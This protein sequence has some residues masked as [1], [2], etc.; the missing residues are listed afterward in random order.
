MELIRILLI[1]D[2][3]IDQLAFKRHIEKEKLTF[4]LEIVKSL[5][6]AKAALTSRAFDI[7]ISDYNLGDGTALEVCKIARGTPLVITTGAGNEEIAVRAMKSGAYDYMIKDAERN[8]LKVLPLTIQKAAHSHRADKQMK[9]LLHAIMHINDSVYITDVSGQILFANQAFSEMY[10][11]AA[12]EIIGKPASL[13]GADGKEGECRHTRKDGSEFFVSLS[14]SRVEESGG[15]TAIVVVARDITE[16]MKSEEALRASEEKYRE[17]F[18]ED[19]AGAYVANPDGK[20]VAC[21]PSFARIFGFVSVEEALKF[22]LIALYP[23]SKRFAD[24]RDLVR[25]NKKLEHYESEMRGRDGTAVQVIQNVM[26]KFSERGELLELKGYIFDNTRHKL[27]EE[28]LRQAQKMESIGTLAGGIAHDFNNILAIIMGHAHILMKGN[29]ELIGKANSVETINRAVQ[30]GAKLVKQIL[31]FARRDEIVFEPTNINH[32]L[33]ELHKMLT[34]TFPK[35]IDF[36][37]KLDQGLPLTIADPNQIHQVLLNLCVNARDA[38]P[39]GGTLTLETEL[40]RGMFLRERYPDAHEHLY[41]CIRVSDT[42]TGMPPEILTKMFEPFFTTKE[43]GKG[44]GLGLA[45][46]YGV[47]KS[48]RGFVDVTS[49]VD[50]GTTFTLYFPIRRR[51]LE[52]ETIIQPFAAAEINGSETIL[53]VEDEAMLL[54]LVKGILESKGYTV[55]SAVDGVEAIEIYSQRK[56]EIGLVLTDLGLPRVD[57]WEAFKRMKEINPEVKVIFASGYI[58]HALRSKLLNAGAKDLVGKPYMP[59]EILNRVRELIGAEAE[60]IR[61]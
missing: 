3:T 56:E 46:V 34:E 5:G 38:M 57:G 10:R 21:N 13:L 17:F 23:K 26:G 48:H 51:E 61:N 30:R 16:Q 37:L 49:E 7:I 20:L 54:E 40:T 36:S 58:D 9:M 44:T 12:D 18:D 19:L 60:V 8:Y 33:E 43:I 47:T 29:P 6:E 42:G 25:L 50:K 1:E 11:Y 55:L 41:A 31:T 15:Q 28:Q 59:E 53:V 32:L 22:N 39:N 14:K 45:V 2:D 4:Q 52:V 35:M 27:L 24:I